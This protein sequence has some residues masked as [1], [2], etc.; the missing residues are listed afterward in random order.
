MAKFDRA[1]FDVLVIGG[2]PAGLTAAARAGQHGATVGI[3]DD[4][5]KLGGQIWRA[6]CEQEH[7][8]T[9]R[10]SEQL[11]RANVTGVVRPHARAI[12]ESR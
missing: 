5:P 7:P 6:T 4:N 2:G 3:V 11:R 1:R 12:V 9:A 8:Q 10:W